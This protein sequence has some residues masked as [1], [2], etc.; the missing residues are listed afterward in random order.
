MQGDEEYR[1]I[2]WLKSVLTVI[3]NKRES[4]EVRAGVD[5]REVDIQPVVSSGSPG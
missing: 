1:A 5:W 2:F 4:P 3:V